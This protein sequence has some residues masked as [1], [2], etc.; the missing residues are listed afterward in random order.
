MRTE[1]E[2]PHCQTSIQLI[3]LHSLPALVHQC[4][5]GISGGR[6]LGRSI[7]SRYRDVWTVRG[8]WGKLGGKS[9][10]LEKRCLLASCQAG[11]YCSRP[12]SFPFQ[13]KGSPCIFIPSWEWWKR[14]MKN[15]PH[16]LQIGSVTSCDN[17]APSYP[18]C[19]AEPH[20]LR[21][22]WN[23]RGKQWAS[24]FSSS[25]DHTDAKWAKHSSDEW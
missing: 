24:S 23:W 9:G 25:P 7:V 4:T 22:T 11:M 19:G 3:A 20:A 17:H 5:C 18:L 6:H 10:Y 1:D 2:S 13:I 8:D 15:N 12:S 21:L 14:K 16:T